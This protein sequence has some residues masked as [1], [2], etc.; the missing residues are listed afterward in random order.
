MRTRDLLLLFGGVWFTTSCTPG[1]GD[2]DEDLARTEVTD[3][4]GQLMY[5]G[6]ALM[7]RSC[8]RG[9]CHNSF[10]EG[11]QRQGAPSGLDYDLGLAPADALG[12][13]DADAIETLRVNQRRIYDDQEAI[14]AQVKGGSMPPKGVGEPFRGAP[15]VKIAEIDSATSSC[16]GGA[17]LAA[18]TTKESKE[19][20]RNWLACGSPVIEVSHPAYSTR[21]GGTVG[22]QVEMCESESCTVGG[23]L[24]NSFE[25][26]YAEVLEVS[27]TAGCHNPMGIS[28]ELDFSTPEN[29]YA[30]LVDAPIVDDCPDAPQVFV[31][32]SNPE[33]SYL[34]HKMVDP[35]LIDPQICGNTMPL[36]QGALSACTELVRAWIAEGAPNLGESDT[37]GDGPGDAGP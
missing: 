33:G 27:C 5:A 4:E 17:D 1:V 32:A 35:S 2:C 14:W 10:A 23:G 19:I 20:L 8:A 6:Q 18:I 9:Q 11:A 21:M 15:G 7:N 25:R 29:A 22:E 31:E 30:S 28:P 34:L 12:V 16:A 26:V 3:T 37:G 24:P 36:G 13:P